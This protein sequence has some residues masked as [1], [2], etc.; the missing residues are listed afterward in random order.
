MK[1]F[2]W[3]TLLLTVLLAGAPIRAQVS[4]GIRIGPPPRPRVVRVLPP[5]P[6]PEFV[7]ID[8]YWYPVGRHYRWHEGYWTRPPYSGARW[9]GPRHDGEEYYEGYW[10]GDRG[11]FPHDHRWDREGDRDR[12]RYHDERREGDRDEH[13]EEHHEDHH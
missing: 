8:G 7:W 9:V 1:K 13:H 2:I 3:T 5:A 11:R 6:G 4:I 12:D 10:D